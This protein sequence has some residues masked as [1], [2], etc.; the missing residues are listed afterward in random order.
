MSNTTA[1]AV[2][3]EDRDGIRILT[4]N[5]PEKKNAFNIGQAVGLKNALEAAEADDSVR[6]IVITGS[7]DAFSSGADMMTFAG[8]DQSGDASDIRWVANL[9][10]PILA[11]TKP[12]IAAVNGLAVGM[13]VTLLPLFDIIYAADTATFATPFVRLGIVV[14]YAASWTLPR[15]LGRNRAN[16]LL[17]RG[18]PIDAQTAYDWGLVNRL[19]PKDRLLDETLAA[20][21][22]II[23]AGPRA[24]RE[25]KRLVRAG[26]E[27]VA[28]ADAF[29]AE[30]AVLATCY[31]SPEHIAQVTAFLNRKR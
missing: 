5:R 12:M 6:V 20:A 27:T 4:L 7:G 24:V 16:E 17:L 14:E 9:H 2:L 19:F 23:A 29:A 26:E 3:S 31:G 1:P 28:L 25:S 8:Q 11:V 30:Q 13:G 21:R 18:T 15:A 22:D 10:E